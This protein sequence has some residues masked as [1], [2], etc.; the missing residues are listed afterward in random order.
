MPGQEAHKPAKRVKA[1]YKKYI[2]SNPKPLSL[3]AWGRSLDN[4][5][6]LKAD[7]EL[8]LAGKKQAKLCL[9]R[10]RVNTKKEKGGKGGKRR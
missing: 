8:W 9:Q 5:S 3:K 4:D 6:S 7:V 10:A 2:K 1:G